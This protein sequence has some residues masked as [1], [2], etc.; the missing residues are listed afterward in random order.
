MITKEH[1]LKPDAFTR[2]WVGPPARCLVNRRQTPTPEA[3][4]ALL[5]LLVFGWSCLV[6][7]VL[8]LFWGFWLFYSVG[9]CIRGYDVL[10]VPACNMLNT[11][12]HGS[13]GLGLCCWFLCKCGIKVVTCWSSFEPTV[14]S[15]VNCGAA[16]I[17]ARQHLL[18]AL[19]HLFM[20]VCAVLN[21]WVLEFYSDTYFNWIGRR[22]R[23]IP[24]KIQISICNAWQYIL[25][26][27]NKM[28]CS[29][30]HQCLL[31]SCH[32]N[33]I[34]GMRSM[35]VGYELFSCSLFNLSVFKFHPVSF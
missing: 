24:G 9:V 22:A 8:M 35:S 26:L 17:D 5:P 19:K 33:R 30:W 31:Y 34:F 6:T 7:W 4:T 32:T 18:K 15:T 23:L 10:F 3:K 12:H 29:K 14:L 25:W 1:K 28:Y 21:D 2:R 20:Y 16:I 13:S 27:S 11:K